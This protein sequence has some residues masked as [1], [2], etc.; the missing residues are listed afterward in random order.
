M[1]RLG[2]SVCRLGAKVCGLGAS[3]SQ[4]QSSQAVMV[5]DDGHAA[6]PAHNGSRDCQNVICQYVDIEGYYNKI[7]PRLNFAASMLS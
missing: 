4:Q 6:S 1:R 5:V 7:S 2:A 3:I